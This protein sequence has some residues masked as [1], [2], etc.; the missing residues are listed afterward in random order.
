MSENRIA[1]MR[2]VLGTS[3]IMFYPPGVNDE[4]DDEYEI[5]NNKELGPTVR[6]V[7]PR[8]NGRAVT[9]NLTAMTGPELQMMREFY[10]LLF[11]LAEPVVRERDKVAQDAFNSGDDAFARIYRQVPQL[12]IRSG[13]VPE[14]YQSI[15]D[16]LGDLANRVGRDGDLEGRLRGD[17][18][19]LAPS[20]P[21]ENRSKDDDT[22]VDKP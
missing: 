15:R 5:A 14:D 1:W 9:M 21:E 11:D 19:E 20:E 18:H 10:D 12:V 4:D 6:L 3:V 2:T 16:R 17:G 8:P 7:L 22:P 13:Q